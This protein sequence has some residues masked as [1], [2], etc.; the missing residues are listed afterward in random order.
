[1]S[2]LDERGGDRKMRA[3]ALWRDRG[4]RFAVGMLRGGILPERQRFLERWVRK[5][6]GLVM[7]QRVEQVERAHSMSLL[8]FIGG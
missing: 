2:N 8:R 5:F 1:M 7:P 6:I 3:E 4:A